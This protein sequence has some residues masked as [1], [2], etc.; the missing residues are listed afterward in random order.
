MVQSMGDTGWSAAAPPA[1][2]E[3]AARQDPAPPDAAQEDL[4]VV[5]QGRSRRSTW[6]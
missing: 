3:D 5:H 6:M 1:E 2:E 4:D